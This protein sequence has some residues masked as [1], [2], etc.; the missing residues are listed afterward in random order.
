MLL[1][2]IYILLRGLGASMIDNRNCVDN[3]GLSSFHPIV[4]AVQIHLTSKRL[5][6]S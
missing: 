5:I 2:A 6:E 3:R 1:A 4:I